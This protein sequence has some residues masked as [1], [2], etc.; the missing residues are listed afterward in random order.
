M[1]TAVDEYKAAKDLYDKLSKTQVKEK[2]MKQIKDTISTLTQEELDEICVPGVPKSET[3]DI[4]LG[5]GDW[6][7]KF[8]V[9]DNRDIKMNYVELYK[10]EPGILNSMFHLLKIGK[11]KYR[12]LDGQ[13]RILA[14]IQK[15]EEE[16]QKFKIRCTV[17]PISHFENE[18]EVCELIQK[19]NVSNKQT[20]GDMLKIFRSQSPWIKTAQK[21]DIENMFS[22]NAARNA[23][24]WPNIIESYILFKHVVKQKKF[25]RV[26]LNAELRKEVWLNEDPLEINKYLSF[27]DWYYPFSLTGTKDLGLSGFSSTDIIA[28][29]AAIYFENI[30]YFN[31][32]IYIARMLKYPQ[33]DQISYQK[34]MED[35]AKF[36]LNTM[37]Y[38]VTSRLI[39]LLGENGR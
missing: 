28:V 20:K 16:G 7:T 2:V 25:S 33:L 36:I 35:L 4:F 1:V 12:I 9:Q 27:L 39:S 5:S 10:N 31:M 38:R 19:I 26:S 34:S 32:N 3:T 11:N 14:L 13:H 15:A 6:N 8:V 30:L 18:L 29:I 21:L 23:I 22:F 24:T 17:Y 37:N